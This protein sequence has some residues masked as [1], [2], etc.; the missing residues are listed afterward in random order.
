MGYGDNEKNADDIFPQKDPVVAMFEKMFPELKGK[1]M[2]VIGDPCLGQ[3]KLQPIQ[4]QGQMQKSNAIDSQKPLYHGVMKPKFDPVNKPEHYNKSGIECIQA[5]EASMTR[6][7]FL[8]F[9]K[10][11]VIKYLWR[12]RYKHNPLE[13][14]NKAKWYLNKLIDIYNKPEV[15]ETQRA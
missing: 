9:L 14:L 8:G 6:E 11:T 7:E 10:G 5:I 13:D 2:Q 3:T 15:M 12:Y 1:V 4:V